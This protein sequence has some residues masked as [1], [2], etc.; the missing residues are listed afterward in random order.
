MPGGGGFA[1]QQY[2]LDWLYSEYCFQEE[3]YGLKVIL[4]KDLCRYLRCKITLF[5]HPSTDFVVAYDRQP[6]FELDKFTY[7]GAHPLNLMLQKHKRF[8][9][10]KFSKPH[11]KLTVKLDYQTSKTN[12]NK[13]VFHRKL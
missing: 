8:V 1:V 7:P 13:M 12:A 11:G 10:S 3:I 5:R 9:L 6:P 4:L 2:S